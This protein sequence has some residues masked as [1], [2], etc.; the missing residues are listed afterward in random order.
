MESVEVQGISPNM[1]SRFSVALLAAA[2]GR[3]N[4]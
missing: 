3:F 1:Q 2:V 4:G